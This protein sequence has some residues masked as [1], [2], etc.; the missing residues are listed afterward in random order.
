MAIM[1][2]APKAVFY[3]FGTVLS[4]IASL[5]CISMMNLWLLPF[6][7]ALRA[8]IAGGD[9]RLKLLAEDCGFKDHSSS[10]AT[11]LYVLS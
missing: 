11:N 3:M 4:I 10:V 1:L 6:E 5:V 9:T 8:A 7:Q 2:L